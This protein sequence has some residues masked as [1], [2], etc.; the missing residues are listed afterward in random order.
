MQNAWLTLDSVPG[1]AVKAI[2]LPDSP[3]WDSQ[4][5]GALLLLSQAEN[6]EK[7]GTLT[8]EETAEAWYSVLLDYIAETTTMIPTATIMIFAGTALPPG[9]LWCRGENV[10]RTT[11]AAL[12]S[13]IGIT[14]GA[15]DGS[16]TFTLPQGEGRVFIG[17]RAFAPFDV[18]GATG[19]SATHLLTTS[20]MPSHTHIQD[21]HNHT[22]N[23]HNHLQDAHNHIQNAHTHNFQYSQIAQS[24]T[25]RFILNT[26]GA[27]TFQSADSQTPTNQA[28]TPTNQANT[29]TNQATT[30]TNQS[31]GGAN[32][33]NNMSPYQIANYIIK[34]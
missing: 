34:F 13:A 28:T 15:G 6:W 26:G 21:A 10:S 25:N 29:A 17:K 1:R 33:H 20:E 14:Y 9:F 8:P 27:S 7:H 3:L 30:A 22:Q 32:A 4:F 18:L 2:S 23:S 12:F 5:V 31:T 16:T 11:Y 19:G 24:G